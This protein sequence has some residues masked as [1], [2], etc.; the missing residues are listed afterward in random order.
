MIGLASQWASGVAFVE[1]LFL[2]LSAYTAPVG[3]TLKAWLIALSVIVTIYAMAALIHE[4][5]HGYNADTLYEEIKNMDKTAVR[6]SIIAIRD[7][8]RYL[9]YRDVNWKCDFFPNHRTADT[10]DENLRQL[11]D[12][13]ST[14][15]DIPETDFALRRVTSESHE[16][17]ST[18]HNGEMRYYDYTLYWADILRTPDAWKHEHFHVDSKDCRWMT[19]DEMLNDPTIREINRDVVS[20]VRDNA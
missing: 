3:I 16:K 5:R 17:P 18:E 10:E 20:M 15:F 11:A 2:I 19:T 4:I 14:G 13:L 8:N 7:G 12:Y 6:S 1:G 9:L